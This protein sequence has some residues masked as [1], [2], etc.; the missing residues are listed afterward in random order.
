MILLANLFDWLLNGYLLGRPQ[1]WGFLDLINECNPGYYVPNRFGDRLTEAVRMLCLLSVTHDGL[2][3]DLYATV[4]RHVQHAVGFPI[5]P[6]LVALRRLRLLYPR[7]A[8]TTLKKS[9][10]EMKGVEGEAESKATSRPSVLRRALAP[11]GAG[12]EKLA[13]ATERLIKRRKSMYKYVFIH[14]G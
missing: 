11:A 1:E 7:C 12:A 5:Y 8:P 4:I 3:E 13:S 14:L 10:S 9:G 2:G 6:M